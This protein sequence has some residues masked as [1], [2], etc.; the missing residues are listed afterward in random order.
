MMRIENLVRI[1][2]D[3]NGV[4]WIKSDWFFRPFFS[5]INPIWSNSFH[6]NLNESEPVFQSVTFEPW[7]H[8]D[9]SGELGQ[10]GFIFYTFFF[11]NQSDLIQFIPFQS[12]W[13]SGLNDLNSKPGSDSLGW[14]WTNWIKSDWFLKK[15]M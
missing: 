15:K 14:N 1:H 7:I 3:W 9:W 12:K 11:K 6:F 4:N 2:L 5:K 13:I 8:L 10:V